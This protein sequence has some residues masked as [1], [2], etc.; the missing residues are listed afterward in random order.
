MAVSPPK[1]CC[2]T[3]IRDKYMAVSPPKPYCH[4]DKRQ[5]KKCIA[6]S[7]TNWAIPPYIC[8]FSNV[9]HFVLQLWHVAVLLISA[10][11][12]SC[13]GLVHNFADRK[14]KL[15]RSTIATVSSNG[16][17]NQKLKIYRDLTTL[18]N[19]LFPK[20]LRAVKAI[21]NWSWILQ[22]ITTLT[23][24]SVLQSCCFYYIFF[25]RKPLKYHS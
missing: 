9:Y 12:F 2:H 11:S 19:I 25:Y 15:K 5:I 3:D 20:R 14:Y 8:L 17:T 21:F 1:P 4:T 10:Y 18:F 13:L 16:P 24:F 22:N 6:V 7:P 23:V